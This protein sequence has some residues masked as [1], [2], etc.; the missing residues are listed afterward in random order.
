MS[1]GGF[2]ETFRVIAGALRDLE[3][4][5]YITVVETAE[6]FAMGQAISIEPGQAIEIKVAVRNT[7]PHPI[8]R[9]IDLLVDGAKFESREIELAA[10]ETKELTFVV[11]LTEIGQHTIS[12]GNVTQVIEVKSSD[13]G[14][15]MVAIGIAVVVILI[16]VVA[17]VAVV[18]RRS[19]RQSKE[20]GDP[21][22]SYE[23]Q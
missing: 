9:T 13:T 7:N 10:G 12:V 4:D 20:N 17:V 22:D 14:I 5:L 6:T 19:G 2:T 15:S 16:I 8:E 23:Q 3:F 21:L 11:T 1:V 18:T